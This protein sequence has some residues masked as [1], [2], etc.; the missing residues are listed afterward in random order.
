MDDAITVKRKP[1]RPRILLEGGKR[2]TVT[3]DPAAM[4]K[5]LTLGAGNPSAGIRAALMQ[6]NPMTATLAQE[7]FADGIATALEVAAEIVQASQVSAQLDAKANELPHAPAT[8]TGE[9]A[10]D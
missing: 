7:R 10:L 9:P 6:A 1:G 3:L 5:A 8:G 4:E 2:L